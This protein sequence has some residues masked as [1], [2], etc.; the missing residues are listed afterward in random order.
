VGRDECG[1]EGDVVRLVDLDPQWITP[2]LFIFRNPTGGD[3]W[4]SCKRVPMTFNEQCEKLWER[5]EFKGR[6][7]VTTVAHMAWQ[8]EGNDFSNLTVTPSIDA[9]ASGNWHG[10]ITNGEIR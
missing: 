6:I 7:I 3:A 4:L 2:D 9:S 8:F 10:F 5:P 1:I